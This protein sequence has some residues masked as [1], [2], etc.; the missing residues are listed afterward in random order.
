[1]A[2]LVESGKTPDMAVKVPYDKVPPHLV[3][4]I[5]NRPPSKTIAVTKNKDGSGHIR[6]I[7]IECN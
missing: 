7:T 6:N 1:M 3:E 2:A 4:D 5:K